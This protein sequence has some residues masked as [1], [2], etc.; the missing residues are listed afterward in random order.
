MAGFLGLALGAGAVAGG[1]LSAGAASDAADAQLAASNRAVDLQERIYDQSREDLE[2]YRLIGTTALQRYGDLLLGPQATGNTLQSQ[3]LQDQ[4]NQLNTEIGNLSTPAQGYMPASDIRQRLIDMGRSADEAATTAQSY[5]ESG[6]TIDQ[7]GRVVD[8]AELSTGAPDPAL[9][10][11]VTQR[12]NLQSQLAAL[13]NPSTEPT[14]PDYSAFY[15]SPGYNFRLQEGE[16]A[17]ER[18]MASRGL[19]NSGRS[20]KDLA[21]HNQGLASEEYNAYMNRLANAAGI[22]QTATQNTAA[23]GANYASNAASGISAA[24]DARASGYVGSANAVN[25]TLDNLF[26]I[27]GQ[28]GWFN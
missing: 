1:L 14:A 9:N 26:K 4:I 17:I 3:Q 7:H 5:F 18:A 10:E 22:G 13:S 28:A 19:R 2:P 23:L 11:L 6:K 8:I 27:S 16:K 15:K 25:S 24:G 12:D 21:A 20:L